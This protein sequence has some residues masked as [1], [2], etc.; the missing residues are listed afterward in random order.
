MSKAAFF[1][2]SGLW[3]LTALL[4]VFLVFPFYYMLVM[5][6]TPDADILSTNIRLIPRA[7][8]FD[9]LFKALTQTMLVRQFLNTVLVAF[10]ILILQTLTSLLAAYAFAFLNFTGKKVLFLI[11]LSTMMMPG[12]TTIVANYLQVSS[13]HWLDTYQVLILPFAASALGIFLFR[14]H[15]LTVA[16]EI[17]EAAMMDGCGE[18]R[19]L[20]QIAAPLARPVAAAFGVTSFLSSWGMYMWP[21][22]VTSKDEMRV[23]QVGINSLQDADS[24][25]SLGLVLASIALITLPS[26]LVFLFGH[27]QLVEGM[28]SGAVKG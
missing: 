10:G 22:L 24:T 20:W 9:N 18:S 25:L 8:S 4:A 19:F 23:V 16:Q 13:W 11:F 3:V 1:K 26:L 6:I 15:F 7:V 5:S 2:K 17:R 27:K 21:L 12:E 28:M 14:Q